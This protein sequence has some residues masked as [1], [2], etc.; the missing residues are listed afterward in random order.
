[1]RLFDL[2]PGGVCLAAHVTARAGR[3]LHDRFTLAWTLA[4]PSQSALCCTL[5]SGRPA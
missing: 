1:M 5:P 2:A 4:R 3:L